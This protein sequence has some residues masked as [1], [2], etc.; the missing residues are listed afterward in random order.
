MVLASLKIPIRNQVGSSGIRQKRRLHQT[1]DDNSRQT[2]R[3]E[4]VLH[5]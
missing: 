2:F 5:T 3:F 4:I 1:K